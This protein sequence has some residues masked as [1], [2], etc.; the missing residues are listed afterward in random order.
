MESGVSAS[1][2]DRKALAA[3]AFIY[4]FPLVFGPAGGQPFA[5]VWLLLLAS[6]KPR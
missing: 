1:G 6:R 3:V 4:G 5:P 2:E